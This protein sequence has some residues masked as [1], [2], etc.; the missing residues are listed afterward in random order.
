MSAVFYVEYRV[1]KVTQIEFKTPAKAR[2]AYK[3]Y[4]KEPEDSAKAYGWELL[5][6]PLTMS[7]KIRARKAG[8]DI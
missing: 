7:Q 2:A 8:V 1:G 5:S 4:C 6:E 3:L